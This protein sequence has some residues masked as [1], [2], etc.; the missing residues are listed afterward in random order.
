M[1]PVWYQENI[2]ARIK[3]NWTT[4]K[5]PNRQQ[6]I[7]QVPYGIGSCTEASSRGTVGSG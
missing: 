5:W 1:V 2:N 4:R 6:E 7:W 3:R